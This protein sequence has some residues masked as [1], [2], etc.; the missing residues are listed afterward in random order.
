ME[1]MRYGD[2]LTH[3]TK[4][5]NEMLFHFGFWILDFGVQNVCQVLV[6]AGNLPNLQFQLVYL[7]LIP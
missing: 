4:L 2:L 7:I 6:V 5:Q 3:P 1:L